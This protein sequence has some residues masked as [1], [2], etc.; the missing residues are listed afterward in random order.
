M[1]EQKQILCCMC[2]KP[3]EYYFIN[4]NGEKEYLCRYC[5]QINE[6]IKKLK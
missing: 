2:R 6:E 5:A 1:S 3:A 4:K